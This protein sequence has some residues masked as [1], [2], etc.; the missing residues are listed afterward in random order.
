MLN[1]ACVQLLRPRV[2]ATRH[3]DDRTWGVQCLGTGLALD[4]DLTDDATQK[5]APGIDLAPTWE[6]LSCVL[7]RGIRHEGHGIIEAP[8]GAL[9]NE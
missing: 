1:V 7:A 4:D 3:H 9:L 8:H 2:L 5:V 6:C